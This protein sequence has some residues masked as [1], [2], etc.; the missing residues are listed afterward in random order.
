MLYS[1]YGSHAPQLGM[2]EYYQSKA[3]SDD[4]L[5]EHKLKLNEDRLSLE[6]RKLEKDHGIQE[7]SGEG[8]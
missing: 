5:L 4:R 7:V 2:A 1:G 3:S 6:K 8:K